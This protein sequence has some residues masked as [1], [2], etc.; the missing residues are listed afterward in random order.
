MNAEKVV[1]EFCHEESATVHVVPPPYTELTNCG[2]R[3]Y[4]SG[5]KERGETCAT[6]VE[7]QLRDRIEELEQQL[8]ER[9][10]NP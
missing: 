10:E 6:V 1:C 4:D 7:E 3:Y 8:A 2:S 9:K 5:A